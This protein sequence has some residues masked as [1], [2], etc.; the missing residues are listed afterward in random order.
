MKPRHHADR[1][2]EKCKINWW[3]IRIVQ[4]CP[5]VDMSVTRVALG[6]S[7][8]ARFYDGLSRKG[9]GTCLGALNTP[10]SNAF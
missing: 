2:G 8:S 4:G 1:L 3:F 7:S 5:K 6:V 9:S 10:I